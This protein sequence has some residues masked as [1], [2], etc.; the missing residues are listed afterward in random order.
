M[1]HC[2]RSAAIAVTFVSLLAAVSPAQQAQAW[3]FGRATGNCLGWQPELLLTDLAVEGRRSPITVV[4]PPWQTGLVLLWNHA[5]TTP[6]F[7]APSG[8]TV[9][10]PQSSSSSVPMPFVTDAYGVGA[11]PLSLPLGISTQVLG[12]QGVILP[13]GPTSAC[14]SNARYASTDG[15][16]LRVQAAGAVV[17]TR[18][19]DDPTHWLSTQPG[20]SLQAGTGFTLGGGVLLT[21]SSASD[22]HA[23]YVAAGASAWQSYEV[24]GEMAVS[25][26]RGGIGVTVYSGYPSADRYYRLRCDSGTST[27]HIDARPGGKTMIG[28]GLNTGVRA[29]AN[30]VYRFRLRVLGGT[31][32]T[33]V[34]ARV[35][36]EYATEPP[37]WQAEALDAAGPYPAGTVGVWATG[38][39]A[40]AWADLEVTRFQN[41]DTAP[42]VLTQRIVD[43][44]AGA[45]TPLASLVVDDGRPTGSPPSVRWS[46]VSGPGNVTFTNA[47]AASTSATFAVP[48]V[49]LL[50]VTADDGELA[51]HGQVIADVKPNAGGTLQVAL[52]WHESGH[53]VQALTVPANPSTG[54]W[55]WTTLSGTSQDEGL[56][57]GDIDRDGRPDLLLGTQWLRNGVGGWS[58]ATMHAPWGPPDRN[59]LADINRDGRLDAVV[60]YESPWSPGRLAWYEQ[61][62]SGAQQTWIE[63]VISDQVIGPMSLDVRDMDG[64]GDLDVV[65]GEHDLNNPAA[66]RALVFEN[67][68]GSGAVWKQHVVY[69]GDEHHDGMQAVDIDNDSDLDIVSTGWT[70]GRVVLYENLSGQPSGPPTFSHVIID[71]SSPAD[72]TCKTLGDIDGDGQ[73]D[74]VAASAAGG[75]IWWY[76]YPS[77]TKHAITTSGTFTTDMQVG[78]VDG[79]GDL[80]VIIPTGRYWGDHL[81]WYE[82]PLPGN[83]PRTTPWKAW[84]IGAAGA[85]DLEVGDVD[86]D[87]RL[88]VLA[89][90][91]DTTLFLQR[92]SPPRTPLDWLPV[93]LNHR[94]SQ[95]SSLGDIDGDGDLDVAINGYWLENPLPGGNIATTWPEWPVAPS[96]P[97]QAG[98]HVADVD[99]DGRADIVLSPAESPN[100]KLSWF[101]SSNPRGGAWTEHVVESSISYVHTMKTADLDLDGRLDIVTAEMHQAPDPDE[102]SVYLNGGGGQWSKM[103]LA[104]TGS[105]NIRVGDIDGDGDIDVFGANWSS[106]APNGAPIEMWRNDLDPGR[107]LDRWQRH[108]I[109]SSRPWQAVFI[110]T[111]DLD[112]DGLKDVVAGGWWYRN[113]G[114]PGGAWQRSA[115]GSPLANMAAVFDFDSDGDLDVLGTQGQGASRNS[116][117][118]WARNDGHGNFTVLTNVQSGQGDFLQGVTVG[119]F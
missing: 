27:F 41:L 54:T 24:T 52:S 32:G 90:N 99:G 106:S 80:D 39:G 16:A 86:G 53:G 111:A 115:L 113:P 97:T 60:G 67:V 51:G 95:G 44:V 84:D 94:P 71:P 14:A 100:G 117:F 83:D 73:L 2:L 78:D 28:T 88:D 104:T 76:E 13:A 57:A 65:T 72:P 12:L 75:G 114:S 11:I 89:R 59:R 33:I 30:V 5:L 20:Y 87:G 112:G 66:A 109:D 56:S 119:R 29:M 21:T 107:T 70:H 102:V 69:T 105:H 96:W 10:A 25:D 8:L 61:P 48:G 82:N 62:S 17:R 110:T 1:F 108:V 47:T 19:T 38:P 42:A 81:W 22:I 46:V 118:A 36:P 116:S 4:A 103:V 26:P 79:D 98:V 9:Y 63:H 68:D 92:G 101:S 74:A 18:M 23:H 15:S 45:P 37:A 34:Q 35:W 85:H 50:R 31:I 58:T 93:K 7:H 6:W 91:S 55:Q 3:H 43:T 64:D 77:W 40:K 49:Y